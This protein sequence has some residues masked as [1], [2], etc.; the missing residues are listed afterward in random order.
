MKK[1]NHK[2]ISNERWIIATLGIAVMGGFYLTQ[3]VDVEAE[4]TN[5]SVRSRQFIGKDSKVRHLSTRSLQTNVDNIFPAAKTNDANAAQNVDINSKVPALINTSF[6]NSNPDVS[7]YFQTTIKISASNANGTVVSKGDNHDVVLDSNDTSVNAIYTFTNT[8]DHPQTPQSEILTLPNYWDKNIPTKV[9]AQVSNQAKLAD[10]TKNLPSGVEL[11]A[12]VKSVWDMKSFSELE[13]D[14]N[15]KWSD[16]NEMKVYYKKPIPAKSSFSISIPLVPQKMAAFNTGEY[17]TFGACRDDFGNSTTMRARYATPYANI[18]TNRQYKAVTKDNS[19]LEYQDAP[20]NIQALMPNAKSSDI[21]TDA[22]FNIDHNT[23]FY[24]G[25]AVNVNLE[26]TNIP[27]LV[28]NQ[29]YSVLLHDHGIPQKVYEYNFTNQ[30]VIIDNDRADKF[31]PYVYIILRKVI[32]TKNSKLRIGA[33]W[34]KTD[35]FIS[36]KDDADRPL[37]SNDMKITVNDPD[38]II[39]DGIAIKSGKL[40]VTYAYKI[41]DEYYGERVPYIVSKTAVINVLGKSNQEEIAKPD[42]PDVSKKPLAP[43]ESVKPGHI[44]KPTEST[45]LNNHHHENEN[46][47]FTV[48]KQ[49]KQDHHLIETYPDRDDVSIYQSD[50]SRIRTSELSTGSGLNSD[51]KRIVEGEAE[52]RVAINEWVKACDVYVYDNRNLIIKTNKGDAQRLTSSHGELVSNRSLS[53]NTRWKVDRL[54]YINGKTY[55]RVATDEFVP[56]SEVIVIRK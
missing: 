17:F 28:K 6:I 27:E 20:E 29:G 36:G 53:A 23:N 7:N 26:S 3:L 16:I 12:T 25:S 47:N 19:N 13:A 21:S 1:S 11:E 55:Y 44:T 34:N 41:S 30:P 40:S 4:T 32:D 8:A 2:Y 14:P 46:S 45:G 38:G 43:S 15:F 42:Q 5:D 35:N 31:I 54:A 56:T 18:A 22:F 50:N 37:K 39:K 51:R 33:K 49:S 9:N 10:I 52:Y 48:Q 24:S